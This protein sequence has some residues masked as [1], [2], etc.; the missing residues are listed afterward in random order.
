MTRS[1]CL[2]CIAHVSIFK[3]S[4]IDYALFIHRTLVV[5]CKCQSTIISGFFLH[6]FF[7]NLKSHLLFQ[8]YLK[9]DI[10]FNVHDRF[11]GYPS[12][13][14]FAHSNNIWKQNNLK[15]FGWRK[16]KVHKPNSQKSAEVTYVLGGRTLSI[17]HIQ[18]RKIIR[19]V[20]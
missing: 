7:F 17:T 20:L 18:C 16:T 5:C 11:L 6:L 2:K 10:Q 4:I 3:E 14:R 1:K 19:T 8:I 9:E 12:F 13:I 15:V